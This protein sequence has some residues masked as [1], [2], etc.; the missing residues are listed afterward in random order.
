M[1]TMKE[2][3]DF[4][5]YFTDHNQYKNERLI[6]LISMRDLIVDIVSKCDHIDENLH[7]RVLGVLDDISSM[8]IDGH[9]ENITVEKDHLRLGFWHLLC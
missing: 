4:C 7:I 3:S 8:V 9:V 5:N 6:Q 1:K 2:I